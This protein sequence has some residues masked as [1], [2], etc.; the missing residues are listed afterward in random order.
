MQEGKSGIETRQDSAECADRILAERRDLN[1]ATV[2]ECM[3][4]KGYRLR[5]EQNREGTATQPDPSKSQSP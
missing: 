4:A 2:R 1:E 5:A 3:E